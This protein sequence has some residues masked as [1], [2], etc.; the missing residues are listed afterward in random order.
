MFNISQID[1]AHVLWR[2]GFEKLQ[3]L[4]REGAR[5]K[6]QVAGRS[7]GVMM[8]FAGTAHPFALKPS[9]LAIKEADWS[10]QQAALRDAVFRQKLI[11]ERPIFVGD[12]EKFVTE[13]FHKMFDVAAG[14]EPSTE[15]SL[16]AQAEGN[17]RLAA[18]LAMDL[19]MKDDGQ[20]MLYFPLFNYSESSLDVLHVLHQSDDVL[21]GLSDAGAHCGAICDGGMPT[22]ML[23]HWSRDRDKPLSLAHV[24]ARQ[25]RDTAK[26]FGLVDRGLLRPGMR[27]DVNVIDYNNLALELP[28]MKWDLP[29][30]GRRLTQRAQGYVATICAGEFIVEDDELTDAR[31]GALVR[32]GR[33]STP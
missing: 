16:G 23:T 15:D 26:Q 18:Q 4:N 7:I 6:A 9:W 1:Q 30:G 27:A 11:D 19:L 3:R 31:P 24:V 25:T 12:F 13:G 8:S 20:G 2:R 29:A 28:K 14:Y 10:V 17:A 22:F 21:M 32:R 5:L 33:A